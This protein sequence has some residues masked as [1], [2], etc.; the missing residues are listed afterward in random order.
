MD[1]NL[2][3]TDDGFYTEQE[4]NSWLETTQDMGFDEFESGFG[5]GYGVEFG[6][7]EI[8]Q[9]VEVENKVMSIAL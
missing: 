3:F 1:P 8:K 9:I 5:R 4:Y 7:R 2:E 6:Y